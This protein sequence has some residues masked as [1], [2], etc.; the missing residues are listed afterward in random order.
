LKF[1]EHQP[2]LEVHRQRSEEMHHPHI[3]SNVRV[4][5]YATT[6]QCFL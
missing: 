3:A 4:R 1:E 6:R 2:A 5:P